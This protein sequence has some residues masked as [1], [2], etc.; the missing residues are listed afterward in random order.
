MESRNTHWL[1]PLALVSAA[2]VVLSACKLYL[3]ETD[4]DG[5][6]EVRF[7]VQQT[8]H[9]G[10]LQVGLV[11]DSV[12]LER[13][14]GDVHEVDVSGDPDPF[15]LIPFS[16]TGDPQ[17][18]TVFGGEPLP[19]G[20]YSR[21][22]LVIDTDASFVESA[23]GVSSLEPADGG[24]QLNFESDFRLEAESDEEL[25]LTV[26]VHAG[27]REGTDRYQLEPTHF[28]TTNATSGSVDVVRPACPEL[29]LYFHRGENQS[30]REL[31]DGD[32]PW[33]TLRPEMG[34][35]EV[36]VPYF[37]SDTYTLWYTCEAD[38]DD[39]ETIDGVEFEQSL[40]L[41]IDDGRCSF[42]E[43]DGPRGEPG[44]C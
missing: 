10:V 9:Q 21:L 19:G 2:A 32:G 17:V 7:A 5:E 24:D 25:V 22:T 43:F 13:D 23:V 37:P 35:S 18:F 12:E 41:G 42:L 27:L 39:P 31:G 4:D 3:P 44:T 6:A 40:N 36:F 16:Q 1:R 11:I 30:A 15:E 14:N 34:R 29:G 8:P 20:D 28:L 38:A 33:F 26:D